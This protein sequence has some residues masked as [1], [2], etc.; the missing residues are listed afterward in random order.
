MDLT[1]A[2]KIRFHNSASSC[3]TWTRNMFSLMREKFSVK[4]TISF[5]EDWWHLLHNQSAWFRQEGTTCRT[6]VN[7][8][9]P[10]VV[11][12]ISYALI[13]EKMCSNIKQ[14]YVLCLLCLKCKCDHSRVSKYRQCGC[15]HTHAHMHARTHTHTHTRTCF[16]VFT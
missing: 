1:A 4:Q 14:E 13:I 9:C 5:A 7:R 8:T 12:Y 11:T 15:M 2:L 6:E 16:G 10:L 3:R